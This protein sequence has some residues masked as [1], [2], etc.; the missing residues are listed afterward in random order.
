MPQHK[1][2]NMKMAAKEAATPSTVIGPAEEPEY[3]YGLALTLD[4]DSLKKLGLSVDG[5]KVGQA[6]ELH[7][8][9][10]VK[11]LSKS[12]SEGEQH[13]SVG[14]QIT[15]LGMGPAA[16]RDGEMA[17]GRSAESVLYAGGGDMVF[18]Q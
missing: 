8:R 11:S 3:P 15:D 6:M 7:A 14:L 4:D 5:L 16:K 1:M 12:E 17:E 10:E 2:V 9:A 18:E 13:Q